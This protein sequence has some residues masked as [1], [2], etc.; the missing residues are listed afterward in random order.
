MISGELLTSKSR[1][2]S[3]LVFFVRMAAGRRS[4]QPVN[5][6]RIRTENETSGGGV[7]GKP[8]NS[9]RRSSISSRSR[10]RSANPADDATSGD[11][12][13]GA[14]TPKIFPVHTPFPSPPAQLWKK[15][16][17]ND[18]TPIWLERM[19]APPEAFRFGTGCH[20]EARLFIN[21]EVPGWYSARKSVFRFE[22]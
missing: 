18:T 15:F 7:G 5:L 16:R 6:D 13:V 3:I 11:K 12:Q 14:Y 8:L 20:R 10:S 19:Q 9:A 4:Y 2:Y 22:C 21:P 1:L 17:E